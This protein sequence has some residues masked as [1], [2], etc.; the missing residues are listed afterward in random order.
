MWQFPSCWLYLSVEL[1]PFAKIGRGSKSSVKPLWL[2]GILCFSPYVFL[3]CKYLRRKSSFV[4]SRRQKKKDFVI[5]HSL[6]LLDPAW[7]HAYHKEEREKNKLS[8]CQEFKDLL[9][10][11][12]ASTE[13][14][15]TG[16]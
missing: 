1:H 15:E 16:V 7:Q 4:C 5:M 2:I 3:L 13:G 9:R 14:H 11:A 12:G 8:C 10:A 6:L